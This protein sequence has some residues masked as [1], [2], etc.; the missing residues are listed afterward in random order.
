MQPTILAS[1][2]PRRSDLLG[3]IGVRFTVIP[4]DADEVH[5]EQLTAVE[6]C[7]L[8]AHRKA[9]AVAKKHPDTLVIGADTLVCLGTRLY[10]KPRHHDE[11][12]RMLMELQGKSHHVVTG[13]SLIHLRSHRESLFAE[14]TT[15][16]FKPLTELQIQAYLERINPLD[17]AGAYA[18]QEFGDMIVADVYGSY[19]NVVGLPVERLRAELDAFESI[20]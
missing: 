8:N 1:A 6:I 9:R 12:A 13:V 11:A 7:Q 17:K 15:V 14:M 10:G 20:P 4:S 19:S 18:V 16:T 2:S 5:T 3:Q